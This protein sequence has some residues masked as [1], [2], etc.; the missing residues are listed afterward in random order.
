MKRIWRRLL[1]FV[2]ALGFFICAP[3]VVLYTAG[4]RYEFGSMHVI[5]TG[6]LTI[7]TIPKNVNIYLDGLLSSKRSPA[8]IDHIFP[9]K[10][11]VR[12]TKDGYSSWEKTLQIEEGKSTFIA[13]TIL[14]LTESPKP[15]IKKANVLSVTPLHEK[16]F[17]YLTKEGTDIE[18]NIHNATF[19]NDRSIWKKTYNPKTT[20]TP[21]WSPDGQFVLL[22]EQTGTTKKYTLIKPYDASIVSIP[23]T[24]ATS[25]WWDVGSPHVLF[26]QTQKGLNAFGV[27][28]FPQIPK[29]TRAQS[30]RRF[31]DRLVVL[32]SQTQAVLSY[33]DDKGVASIITYIPNGTYVFV[34]SPESLILLQ[35]KQ[36]NKLLL[37]DPSAQ[38]P[39]LMQEE[40]KEW[41][42]S[43][44]NTELLMSSGYD[45]KI[46]RTTDRSVET[47][48]RFSDPISSLAWYPVESNILFVQNNSIKTI[49]LDKRDKR[50]E[51]VLVDGFDAQSFWMNKDGSNLYFLGKNTTGDATI[52]EKRLQK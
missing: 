12:L 23:F 37:I 46:F 28:A 48:T 19:E 47:I 41:Q 31:H 4:Y 32:Q 20:Y 5:K 36:Q 11:T 24:S 26:A 51:A 45:A 1:F 14:F 15:F 18:L 42:W 10:T 50:N 7:S 13:N 40:A 22:E 17:A 38:N 35:N 16:L 3:L 8:V 21:V 39:I 25:I 43:S 30:A 27:D 52:F 9:G 44:N 2:F 6:A 33:I 29:N 34:P 49:E